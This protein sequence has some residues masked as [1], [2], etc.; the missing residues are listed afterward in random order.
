MKTI[1]EAEPNR[2]PAFA[3]AAPHIPP[4]RCAA[5]HGTIPPT[6]RQTSCV[7]NLSRL[8]EPRGAAFCWNR[9]VQ[10]LL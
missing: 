10:R 7:T 5:K 9:S 2:P 4:Q 3:E 1:S 6:M 8:L